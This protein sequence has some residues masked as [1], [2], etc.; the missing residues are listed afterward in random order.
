VVSAPS[1]GS[2]SGFFSLASFFVSSLMG[3]EATRC[4]PQRLAAFSGCVAERAP[5][6]LGANKE[7]GT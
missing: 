7:V 3:A 6:R 4:S 5:H 1:G 2:W